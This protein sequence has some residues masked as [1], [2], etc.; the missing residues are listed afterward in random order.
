MTTLQPRLHA[1]P[2]PAYGR[3]HSGPL[4]ITYRREGLTMS[5]ATYRE[6]DWFTVPLRDGTFASGCLARTSRR[7]VLFGYFFGPKRAEPANI[8]E[9]ERLAPTDA[10]LLCMFGHLALKTGKWPVIGQR[11]CWNR[12]EWP[13]PLLA[14]HEEF[15][16]RAFLERYNDND[17][18]QLMEETAVTTER[19]EGVPASALF[20]AGAVEIELTE[21]L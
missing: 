8:N 15:S 4:K 13:I 19:A 10:S 11:G 3:V 6:G 9:L 21:K 18:S 16:E 2:E 7:G 12:A 14:R 17:P 20:G 1:P 5:G